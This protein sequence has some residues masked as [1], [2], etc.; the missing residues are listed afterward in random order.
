[1]ALHSRPRYIV[2][3]RLDFTLMLENGVDS[4]AHSA[5]TPAPNLRVVATAVHYTDISA[6]C[7]S[8]RLELVRYHQLVL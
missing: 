7:M 6:C 1:M 8:S 4:D 2:N 3:S 5:S